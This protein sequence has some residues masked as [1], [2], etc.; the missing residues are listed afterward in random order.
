MIPQMTMK[1]RIMRPRIASLGIGALHR[2]A[3]L[4]PYGWGRSNA[5]IRVL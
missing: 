3:Q 1:K 4:R 5:L 2:K